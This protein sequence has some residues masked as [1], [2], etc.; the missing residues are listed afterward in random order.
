MQKRN[1]K[2]LLTLC[3][4]AA[5]LLGLPMAALAEDVPV[6]KITITGGVNSPVAGLAPADIPTADITIT[7]EPDGA[8]V[9]RAT[10]PLR[11]TE[12]DG[13]PVTGTFAWGRTYKLT[14]PVELQ[15]PQPGDADTPVFGVPD[16]ISVE[17]YTLGIGTFVPADATN[18]DGASVVFTYE[19]PPEPV[20]SPGATEAPQSSPTQESAVG[21]P[22]TGEN[23]SGM[24]LMIAM[25]LV[26]TAPILIAVLYAR[27]RRAA[28]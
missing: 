17:S 8:V 23:G 9:V 10:E 5:L 25:S 18:N 22:S 19:I 13:T 1:T 7:S 21:V 2:R 3:L 15:Q 14:I 12:N 11:W 24:T 16:S 6:T 26:F 4:A 28:K 20:P 27:K